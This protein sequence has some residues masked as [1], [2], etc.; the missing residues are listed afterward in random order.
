VYT[1]PSFFLFFL[2]VRVRVVVC[3]YLRSFYFLF[4]LCFVNIIFV[5]VHILLLFNTLNN[6]LES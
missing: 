4:V 2:F 1:V 3:S 6:L 5:F